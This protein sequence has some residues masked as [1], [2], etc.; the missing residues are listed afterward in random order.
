MSCSCSGVFLHSTQQGV[1]KRPVTSLEAPLPKVSIVVTSLNAQM[2]I[3]DCLNSL[4]S[5]DYGN[6]EVILVDGGSIDYTVEKARELAGDRANFH[7]V[8]NNLAETP[9][10]GRNEGVR[11]TNGDF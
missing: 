9:A 1:P 5:Q 8:S 7:V 4:F 10:A 3:G 11:R 6:F 2:S